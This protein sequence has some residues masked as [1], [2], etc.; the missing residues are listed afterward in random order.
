MFVSRRI[1][2]RL[3]DQTMKRS[4]FNRDSVLVAANKFPDAL[5][6]GKILSMRSFIGCCICDS[7]SHV[8]SEI[9][10]LFQKISVS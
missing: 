2:G 9:Q 3:F 10:Y 1:L 5:S 4:W 8:F 6:V 7:K